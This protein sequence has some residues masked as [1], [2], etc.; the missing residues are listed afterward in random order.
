MK[1]KLLS[2]A[3]LF[4]ACSLQLAACGYTSRSMISNEYKTIYVPPFANKINITQEENVANK[5]RIYRPQLETD[6]TRAVVNKYLFDGNLK[7]VKEEAADLILK[8]EV[9]EFRNDP[10][11]YDDNNEALE[12][13]ISLLVNLSLWNR[14]ENRLIW[15]ENNFTGESTY[16]TSGS[17]A[18]SE[19]SA[20][21]DAVSDLARR[22]VER[23]VEQW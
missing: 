20:I 12:Y 11:R 1:T 14:K 7:P 2:L 13:R 16:F 21:N 19:A 5:Y 17:Q 6:I 3:I 15:Q 10:L 22:V 8:G 4:M 18:K 9:L 23:T